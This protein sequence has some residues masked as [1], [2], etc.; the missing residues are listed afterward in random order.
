MS[1][2]FDV[3]F[4]SPIVVPTMK[5][6]CTKDGATIAVGHLI[7][8]VHPLKKCIFYSTFKTFQWGEPRLYIFEGGFNMLI[9]DM[10]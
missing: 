7:L 10:Q 4:I 2:T 9:V 3:A 1:E 5:S 6:V 8:V